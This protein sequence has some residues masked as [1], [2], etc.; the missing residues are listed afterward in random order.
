MFSDAGSKVTAQ[1]INLGLKVN[2]LKILSNKPIVFVAK[3]SQC[4]ST[5]SVLC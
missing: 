1:V 4:C 2:I 5:Y 3:A